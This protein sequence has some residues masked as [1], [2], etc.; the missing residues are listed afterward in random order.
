[1]CNTCVVLLRGMLAVNGSVDKC[2]DHYARCTSD[3]LSTIERGPTPDTALAIR[4]INLALRGKQ[5]SY[6]LELDLGLASQAHHRPAFL[7]VDISNAYGTRIMQAI[8]TCEPFISYSAE[9]TQVRVA[10]SLP[11]LV[12]GT[13]LVSAWV[14]P[15][16]SHTFDYAID[17]V[18]FQIVDSPTKGRTHPHSP[19]FGSIV[20]LSSYARK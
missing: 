2:L 17:Q 10:V 3:I 9:E 11:P 14:G 4:S 6:T 15:D 5:P 20:P 1:M 19:D 7:A 16:F 8:P 12:P 18:A 13:Y